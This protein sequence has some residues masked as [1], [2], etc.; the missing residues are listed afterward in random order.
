MLTRK[1]LIKANE[2]LCRN[3]TE[4][5]R[6][7]ESWRRKCQ[8]LEA[9]NHTL[10]CETVELSDLLRVMA[11]S[12]V[13]EGGPNPEQWDRVMTILYPGLHDPATPEREGEDP[14]ALS[15]GEAELP[16]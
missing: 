14:L 4:H 9:I 5:R 2:T 16:F 7:I 12:F 6:V 11:E 15:N 13:G 10:V 3:D 8:A 1:Q